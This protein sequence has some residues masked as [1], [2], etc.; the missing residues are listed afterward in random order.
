MPYRH[1]PATT[2]RHFPSTA[3]ALI[4]A[5]AAKVGAI[6]TVSAGSARAAGFTPGHQNRIGTR[7]S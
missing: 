7:R 1:F 5:I 4:P 2:A 6:S 3:G